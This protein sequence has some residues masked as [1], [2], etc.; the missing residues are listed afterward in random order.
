ML[1]IFVQN[2]IIKLPIDE[3]EIKDCNHVTYVI[4]KDEIK[5]AFY[6]FINSTKNEICFK[7]K[8]LKLLPDLFCSAFKVIEAAGGIVKNKEDKY[9][10]IFRNGYWD[11]P[12]GKIEKGEDLKSCAI[13]EVEEECKIS[14]L[15]IVNDLSTTYHM[16]ELHKNK[17]ALK[18]TYWY[19][20]FTNET[21]DPVPQEEE[22][23][24]KAVWL[25]KNEIDKVLN[26]TYPSI[27]QIIKEV[28]KK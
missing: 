26:N 18:I 14:G 12:K 27:V 13:R 7:S 20:M 25:P 17:W 8:N 2:R 24:I 3:A 16:Y 1:S 15:K 5:K 6:D 23:I 21:K 22:G 28:I 11:L 10:F 4:K 19:E 9:L